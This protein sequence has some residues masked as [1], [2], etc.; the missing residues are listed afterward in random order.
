MLRR[1]LAGSRGD[2]SDAIVLQELLA[3]ISDPMR[4]PV[5]GTALVTSLFGVPPV[6]WALLALFLV[7]DRQVL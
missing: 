2:A 3:T 7:D 1:R 5:L 6:G 4:L